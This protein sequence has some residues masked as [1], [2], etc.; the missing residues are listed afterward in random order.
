MPQR[1][2]DLK[3]SF[4]TIRLPADVKSALQQ[5]ARQSDRTL[6][7][8]ALNYIKACLRDSPAK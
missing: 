5:Q 1:P 2:K 3:S 8:Q 7:A 6:S 4:L